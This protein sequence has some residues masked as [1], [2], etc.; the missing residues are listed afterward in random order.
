MAS[1]HVLGT[2]I[3][4]GIL[5][6]RVAHGALPDSYLHIRDVGPSYVVAA[7]LVA[8]IAY[9]TWPGRVLCAIG[10]LIVAPDLFGGLFQL[11]VS[12]VGHVCA[13]ATALGVGAVFA[14]RRRTA[15]AMVGSDS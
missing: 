15:D 7:A 3:S 10:F 8:G 2:V 6:Y 5:W 14:Y 11:E 1:A 13:M 4:E 9:A 12:A